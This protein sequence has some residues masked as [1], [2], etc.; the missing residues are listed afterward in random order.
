MLWD[1]NANMQTIKVLCMV[2]HRR[3]LANT[4]HLVAG[5]PLASH[6]DS[7]LDH[8]FEVHYENHHLGFQVEWVLVEF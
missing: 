3:R 2:N 1:V 7:T 6:A 5:S 4:Y 8:L